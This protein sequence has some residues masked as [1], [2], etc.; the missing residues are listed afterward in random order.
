VNRRRV[1]G[2]NLPGALQCTP[3]CLFGVAPEGSGCGELGVSEADPRPVRVVGAAD[4]TCS[5]AA[6]WHGALRHHTVPA[7]GIS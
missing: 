1:K 3:N 6:K 7:G 2:G 5:C 4:C